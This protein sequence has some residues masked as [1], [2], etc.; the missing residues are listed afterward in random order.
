[1]SGRYTDTAGAAERTTL[2]PS[3]LAKKRLS[4]DG[5]PFVKLGAKVVYPVDELDAWLDSQPRRRSTS[6][7][8]DR[9]A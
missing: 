4:G 1:M 5:P 8:G 6:D 3:T 9:A 7:D 2:S